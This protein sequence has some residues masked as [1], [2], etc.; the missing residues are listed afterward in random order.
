MNSLDGF[1]L[2]SY[3]EPMKYLGK[4]SLS[5]AFASLLGVFW[6]VMLAAMVLGVPL[7]T[8]VLFYYPEPGTFLYAVLTYI[9]IPAAVHR[10][11]GYK[12]LM[13]LQTGIIVPVILM[14]I[15]R[16]RMLFINFSDNK[17][18]VEDNIKILK[19]LVL[20]FILLSGA[21]LNLLSLIISMILL[22]LAEI[23]HRGARLQEEIDWIV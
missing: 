17:I 16:L 19:G 1:Y 22:V 9:E 6:W 18:F 21:S 2:F 14:L 20:L 4:K 7:E 13:L 15:K 8:L 5:S 3:D 23:F 11:L 12:L 10:T